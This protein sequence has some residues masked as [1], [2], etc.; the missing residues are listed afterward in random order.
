MIRLFLFTNREYDYGW[1]LLTRICRLVNGDCSFSISNQKPKIEDKQL[2]FSNL[3]IV[4]KKLLTEE[5]YEFLK[6]HDKNFLVYE[7]GKRIRELTN[8]TKSICCLYSWARRVKRGEPYYECSSKGDKRFSAI[9]AKIKSLGNKSIEEIYQLDLKGYR[10]KVKHWKEAKGLP[11]LNNKTEDELFKE[12]VSLWK[13]Y[14]K[15]NPELLKEIS[16]KA[17]GKTIT[18]MFGVTSINQ[19]RAIAY[20]LNNKIDCKKG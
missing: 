17:I 5:M 19:A 14:F 8:I 20:I 9:F 6:R 2:L 13:L 1:K 10:N 4:E 7:N 18:D 12:Y 16:Q 15:E 11:P 3:I